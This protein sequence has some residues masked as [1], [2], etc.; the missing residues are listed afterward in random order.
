MKNKTL[1]A[2]AL[3]F[4]SAIAN[5]HTMEGDFTGLT[6]QGQ[7]IERTFLLCNTLN[8]QE[9]FSLSS[10][11]EWME[12][13][14]L[15]ASVPA[16]SCKEIYAFI[17][18]LPYSESGEYQ[19]EVNAEGEHESTTKTFYLTV[20]EGHKIKI[21]SQNSITTTQCK[22]EVFNIE[23]ENTGIFDERALFSVQGLNKNWFEL[24]SK[25]IFLPKNSKRN[26]ELNVLIPC[27][28]ETKRYDF[29]L[30]AELKNTGITKE[31]NLSINVE[32][33]QEILIESR[34]FNACNDLTAINSLS[35]TNKG[36]MQEELTLQIE[37]PTWIKLQENSMQLESGQTKEIQIKFL[38]N[39]QE[40]K[41]YSFK[42]KVYSEKFNQYYKKNFTVKAENCFD[43]SIENGQ[44]QNS[45][46]IESNPEISYILKNTGTKRM[47]LKLRIEGIKAELEK[48]SIA[49]EPN[50]STEIKAQLD[51]SAISADQLKFILI[52]D[53][54]NYSNTKE[55]TMQLENCYE[56][57]S[58]VPSLKVCREVP[59]KNQFIKIS[60]TGTKKQSFSLE[61][62]VNWI[63]LTEKNFS[64][65]GGQTKEIE[66]IIMPKKTSQEETYAVKTTTENN[67][68]TMTGNIEYLDKETCFGLNMQITKEIEVNAGEGAITTI[69][70]TNQGKTLQHVNF[71]VENYS[72]VFFNPK[73]FD[74]MEGET[75][76]VYVYFNPP[77]DFEQ[78]KVSVQVKAI[79]NYDF[80]VQKAVKVI[81]SGGSVILTID[82]ENIN[83]SPTEIGT[84][85]TNENKIEITIQLENNTEANMKILD[86][87]TNYPKS[88]YF[89]KEPVIKKQTTGEII[90]IFVANQKLELKGL[91]VPIEIVTDKG[92]YYKVVQLP[93]ET[94]KTE[95]GEET[96]GFILFGEDEYIL[97]ILI[98]LIVILIILAAVRSD[99][100][101]TE[102]QI[103]D[104][105]PEQDFQKEIKSIV[106][107]KP[108]KKKTKK[109]TKKT[110]KKK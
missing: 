38:E 27:N 56:I 109:K 66:L 93:K 107:K 51:F 12:V 16:E 105:S 94:E 45:A 34:S 101:E 80:L 24:S 81:V 104:Y 53:S 73:K 102:E 36:L 99:K 6:F 106:T 74:L 108:E 26:L 32:N 71:L 46:C 70:I 85:D 55:N 54:E 89:I 4:L 72:W 43:L 21:E 5:A 33:A 30:Q 19:I 103:V 14:P 17:T 7:T 110:K 97:V 13:R 3:I 41:N 10:N 68:Y 2:L 18:P 67:Q 1:I 86:V 75:K 20:L 50:Q 63:N 22:E 69:Q 96:T 11:N 48:N 76:E 29:T 40:E 58:V 61:S 37:G 77:F 95:D 25:E 65:E 59:L 9:N 60:N 83:V 88:N 62:N 79:T 57:Q 78:E 39:N 84:E 92:T 100:E 15:T 47:L 42:L 87:K 44:M 82:P 8:F 35:I 31:K 52:A 91:E 28:Q 23:L 90:L 98:V 49:L 64:L